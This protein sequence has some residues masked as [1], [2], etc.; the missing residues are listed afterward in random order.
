MRKCLVYG[1]EPYLIDEFRKNVIKEVEIPEMN[2]LDTVEFDEEEQRF[3]CQQSL[4]GGKKV[5]IFRAKSLKESQELISYIADKKNDTAVYI[6]C[7]DIDKRSKVYKSFKEDEIKVCNKIHQDAL[8]LTCVRFVQKAGCKIT[9]EACDRFL[10]L[11]N[12]YSDE[13]NLYDVRNSLKRLCTYPEITTEVVENLV[14]DRQTEDI[15]SLIQLIM[16]KKPAEVYR[17]ADLILQNQKNNVIGILSLLLRSYRLAYK[18]QVCNCTLKDLN[19]NYRTYV[20]RL[21]ADACDQAMNIIEKAVMDIKRGFY[22]PEI[23]L[24]ITLSKLCIL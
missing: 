5:M 11:I 7:R 3:L 22:T 9:K 24:K 8:V 21:S 17:Q 12:Y 4:F 19:V 6:F 18:M 14:M 23:A 10:E 2:L 1:D 15:Y 13:V 16:Q 20:P